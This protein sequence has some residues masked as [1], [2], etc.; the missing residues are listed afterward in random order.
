MATGT[1]KGLNPSRK[2]GSGPDNKGLSEATILTGYATDLGVGDLVKRT[3]DGTLQQGENGAPD[4]VGCYLGVSYTD[5]DGNPVFKQRWA[6]STT[7]TDI[8]AS[9]NDDPLA[10]YD[11]RA[12][13]SIAVI[14]VGDL[15]PVRFDSTVNALTGRSNMEVRSL[16]Q[17]TATAIDFTG[18]LDIGANTTISDGDAF[19]VD[20]ATVNSATTITI[21][22]GDGIIE[23]LAD[24]NAVTGISGEISEDGSS[25]GFLTI[26]A[27]DGSQLRLDDTTGTPLV[28]MGIIS[29]G[30][31]VGLR[32]DAPSQVAETQTI[33]TSQDFRGI[34]DIGN[35]LDMTDADA[36]VLT[37]FDFNN[38]VEAVET[39]TVTI[40]GGDGT[41]DFLADLNVLQFC[42][43]TLQ[44]GTGFLV[45]TSPAGYMIQLAESVGTPLADMGLF[46]GRT[47]KDRSAVKVI[48]ITDTTNN[49][50]EVQIL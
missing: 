16:A 21:A 49:V 39:V 50:L 23:L 7:A 45:L 22:D 33:A 38:G 12:D 48:G 13:G 29:T 41:A 34:A 30:I 26:K 19:T 42:V 27:T 32:I 2:V 10:T 20:T 47:R 43:A 40:A 37:V 3:T 44:E 4:N 15:M 6:A 24:I 35:D 46:V 36:L 1:K 9:L 18:E 31:T 17:A 5:S 8:K 25:S 14:D 11:A 28:D